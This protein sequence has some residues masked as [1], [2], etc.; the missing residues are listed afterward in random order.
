MARAERS[1]A[2]RNR[3]QRQDRM[4]LEA[5]EWEVT[6]PRMELDRIQSKRGSNEHTIQ[7]AWE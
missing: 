1:R 6:G 2:D 5:R 3:E 7:L 4:T